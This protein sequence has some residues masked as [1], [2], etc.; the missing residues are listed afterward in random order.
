MTVAGPAEGAAALNKLNGTIQ[1]V[2]HMLKRC[3]IRFA[4][5]NDEGRDAQEDEELQMFSRQ[6]LTQTIMAKVIH[7]RLIF[8]VDASRQSIRRDQKELL[9]AR[10]RLQ[11]LEYEKASLLKQISACRAK[12][13]V[14]TVEMEVPLTSD[15]YSSEENED[16]LNKAHQA[17]KRSLQDE[18]SR[19]ERQRDELD[20]VKKMIEQK[21]RALSELG[22]SLSCMPRAIEAID[23]VVQPIHSLVTQHDGGIKPCEVTLQGLGKLPIPLYVLARQFQAVLNAFESPLHVAIVHDTF[24][25]PVPTTGNNDA[26]E[27]GSGAMGSNVEDN[28]LY[29]AAGHVVK[30]DIGAKGLDEELRVYF[31]YLDVL[32]LI[33]VRASIVSNGQER[34]DYP[35]KGLQL[36]FPRDTGA[37]S[38]KG[39]HAYLQNGRFQYSVHKGGGRAFIWANAICGIDCLPNVD[40]TCSQD[41]SVDKR[42]EAWVREMCNL[43]MH[44]R[45]REV[46][47]MLQ[48]RLRSIVS[49]KSQLEALSSNRSLV[50]GKALGF[51]KDPEAR[52]MRFFKMDSK[53][54]DDTGLVRDGHDRN[55]TEVW[56]MVVKGVHDS[57]IDCLIALE[58]DYPQGQA[59]FRIL[60]PNSPEHVREAHVVEM[61]RHIN[62][63]TQCA[64]FPEEMMLSVQVTTLLALVDNAESAF[65]LASGSGFSEAPSKRLQGRTR[66]KRDE[67]GVVHL[68]E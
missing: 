67:A 34:S 56:G 39:S 51:N 21:R 35:V 4:E 46:V 37:T 38:P 15:L 33:V 45:V 63:L 41:G 44:I 11:N 6:L 5:L 26:G 53:T 40:R 16:A 9:R 18:L 22:T 30:V 48:K 10:L 14:P 55:E 43:V 3:A 8:D 31:R 1:S 65:N 49:L 20:K 58:A 25:S 2:R 68:G 57:R 27:S 47:E 13:C 42:S 66:S 64:S 17:A 24:Q 29:H 32:E 7:D 12:V 50:K 60:W 61:E 28:R 23:G 36:L 52:I 54:W 62:Q 19:R 59:L